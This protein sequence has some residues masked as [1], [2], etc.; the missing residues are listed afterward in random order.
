[1]RKLVGGKIKPSQLL[2]K[3]AS[4]PRQNDLAVALREV[5]RVKRTLFIIEWILDTDMQRR[6]QIGLNKGE[7]HHAL[8][9]ALR[10]GR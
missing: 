10:I 9:N 5:G 1:M 3:L 6:A 2:R 8:K 7:A 4:Y